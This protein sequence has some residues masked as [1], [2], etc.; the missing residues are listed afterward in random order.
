MVKLTAELI[1]QAA[2]YTNAVRDRE[3]DLRGECEAAEGLSPD[4]RAPPRGPRAAACA[5]AGPWIAGFCQPGTR[6]GC[7]GLIL[8]FCCSTS[9]ALFSSEPSVTRSCSQ[10]RLLSFFSGPDSV[11][12]CSA[13]SA[14]RTV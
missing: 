2:Q 1:E 8:V 3:L 12:P 5:E 13:C 7:P 9:A 11:R 4:L 10:A 6:R 14:G